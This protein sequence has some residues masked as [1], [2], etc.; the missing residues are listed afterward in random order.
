MPRAKKT[1][2]ATLATSAPEVSLPN[3]TV[4]EK[5]A[6]FEPVELPLGD[7]MFTIAPIASRGGKEAYN[8]SADFTT[9]A[10]P[11]VTRMFNMAVAQQYTAG[12]NTDRS[13]Q[14]MLADVIHSVGDQDMVGLVRDM[15]A[16]MAYIGMIACK[17]TDTDITEDDVKSLSGGP[18]NPE[19]TQIVFTQILADRI[20]DTVIGL[21]AGFAISPHATA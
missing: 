1:T 7:R 18:L 5:P 11:L 20:L 17:S 2:L 16:S 9:A 4:P 14:D 10:I 15:Q 8:D 21:G 6:T 19:L 13:E 3:P 12:V